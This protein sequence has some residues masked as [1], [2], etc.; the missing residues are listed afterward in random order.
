MVAGRTASRPWPVCIR[1]FATSWGRHHPHTCNPLAS[2]TR[3]I[4]TTMQNRGPHS[5]SSLG[6]PMMELEL[7]PGFTLSTLHNFLGKRQQLGEMLPLHE[8]TE[9]LDA[10]T[11]SGLSLA[12]SPSTFHST[13]ETMGVEIRRHTSGW[14]MCGQHRKNPILSASSCD[15]CVSSCTPAIGHM[16]WSRSRSHLSK[17]SARAGASFHCE[18]SCIFMIA[19][20]SMWTSYITSSWT[21]L[22]QGCKRSEQKRLL[23]SGCLLQQQDLMTHS[24][25]EMTSVRPVEACIKQVQGQTEKQ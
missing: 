3:A 7:L 14:P 2:Q 5:L 16:T 13:G 21:K 20:Q 12:T 17:S 22:T 4:I 19:G 1:L 8:S 25:L 18:C 6:T 23:T 10:R 24:L 9:D 15:M 11:E